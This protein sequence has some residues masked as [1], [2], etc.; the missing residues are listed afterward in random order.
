MHQSQTVTLR[1]SYVN[2]LHHKIYVTGRLL[3]PFVPN[4]NG[5]NK[6]LLSRSGKILDVIEV[7]PKFQILH[8]I[9]GYY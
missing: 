1:S 6:I 3:L 9:L 7:H 4:Y 8:S 2:M 5:I